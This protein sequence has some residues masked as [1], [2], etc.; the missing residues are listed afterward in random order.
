MLMISETAQGGKG[1]L[2]D[3]QTRRKEESARCRAGILKCW[4]S[5]AVTRRSVRTAARET[6]MAVYRRGDVYWYSFIFA[7]QRVQ[8]SSKSRSKTVAKEAEK[9]RHRELEAAI[10]GLAPSRDSR[11]RT[12]KDGLPD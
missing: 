2:D 4:T 1:G 8:E 10:N 3:L 6:E 11:I 7:G 12:I 5:T 9:Q